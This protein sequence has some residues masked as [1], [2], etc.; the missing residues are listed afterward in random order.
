MSATSWTR[1]AAD[2]A[3]CDAAAWSE[4]SDGE[5]H[6]DIKRG[7]KEDGE[8][9]GARDG[10]LGTA[11]FARRESDV[12]VAPITIGGEKRGLGETAE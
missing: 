2:S 9:D 12:V 10:A 1:R 8:Q 6:E 7:D 5:V 11:D 3:A 4:G